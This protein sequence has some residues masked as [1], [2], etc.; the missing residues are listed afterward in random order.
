[1]VVEEAWAHSFIAGLVPPSTVN[2][3]SECEN[4]V[5]RVETQHSFLNG[6]VAAITFS[7]Y[8]PMQITVTCA[9][10]GGME[11]DGAAAAVIEVRGTESMAAALDAAALRSWAA[12]GSPVYVRGPVDD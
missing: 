8:T 6:L 11:E 4:G 3:A 12:L 10:P 5:A 1:M 9:A 2:V 7:I